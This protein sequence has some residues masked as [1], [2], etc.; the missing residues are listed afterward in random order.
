M[1][2]FFNKTKTKV[3]YI[4]L[5]CQKIT[6]PSDWYTNGKPSL[7][8]AEIAICNLKHSTIG[9]NGYTKNDLISSFFHLTDP[10]CVLAFS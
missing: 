10:H 3:D 7:D 2:L 6:K 1:K 5:K 8:S 4:V 9:L